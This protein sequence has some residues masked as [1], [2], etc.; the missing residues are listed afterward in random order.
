M[1]GIRF[2]NTKRYARGAY[3]PRAPY[4]FTSLERAKRATYAGE[5][6]ILAGAK[7]PRFLFYIFILHILFYGLISFTYLTYILYLQGLYFVFTGLIFFT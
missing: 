5:A 2:A 6:R 7:P 1:R 4:F 3:A